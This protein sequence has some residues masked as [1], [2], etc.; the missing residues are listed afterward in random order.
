MGLF[1]WLLG[2][3]AK[4]EK[5]RVEILRTIHD[6]VSDEYNEQTLFG[7]VYNANI[8]FIMASDFIVK[9]VKEND[10]K[11]LEMVKSCLEDSFADAVEF[12]KAEK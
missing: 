1:S 8:E 7:N 10:I 4:D 3:K 9:L 12:I 2:N 6:K 5:G 11:S